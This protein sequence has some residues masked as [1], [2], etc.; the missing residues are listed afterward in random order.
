MSLEHHIRRDQIE[1]ELEK[2]RCK[3]LDLTMRN[4][5]LNFRPAKVSTIRVIDEVPREIYDILVLQE[6]QMSFDA[7]A[8]LKS[9][10]EDSFHGELKDNGDES[11]RFSV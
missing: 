9:E 1:K 6:K 5:L 8:M 11:V 2:A 10:Q 7:I 3:L 4:R